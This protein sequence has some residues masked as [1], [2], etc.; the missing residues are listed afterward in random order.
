[1]DVKAGDETL[2]RFTC[3]PNHVSVGAILVPK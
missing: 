2:K 1:M 3:G